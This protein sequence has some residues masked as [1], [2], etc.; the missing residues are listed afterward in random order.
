MVMQRQIQQLPGSNQLAGNSAVF[1]GWGG[2]TAGMVVH[3][4]DAGGRLGDGGAE[5]FAGM[6]ERAIEDA[7]SDEHFAQHPALAV[8]GQQVEFFDG[9]VTEPRREAAGHVLRLSYARGERALLA[10][11]PGANFEGSDET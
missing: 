10:G 6:H 8:E 7:A 1:G 9:K 3:H 11:K 4:D 2:I 5:N